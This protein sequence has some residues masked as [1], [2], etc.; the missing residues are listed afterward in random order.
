MSATELK[1]L[2]DRVQSWPKS[3]QDELLSMAN[4]IE[5]ALRGHQHVASE[6]ELQISEAAITSID[7]K[8]DAGSG[9]DEDD[10]LESMKRLVA[11]QRKSEKESGSDA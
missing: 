5:N 11:G 1:D 9:A 6:V 2:F 4:A 8:P 3:A 10:I 7:V